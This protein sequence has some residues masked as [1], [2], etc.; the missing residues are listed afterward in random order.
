MGYHLR[1]V[2]VWAEW[3]KYKNCTVTSIDRNTY[4]VSP[5]KSVQLKLA[6]NLGPVIDVVEPPK[7]YHIRGWLIR[8][9][10]PVTELTE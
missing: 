8:G 5:I 1:N 7:T 3:L 10:I 6:P 4:S 2:H 9:R